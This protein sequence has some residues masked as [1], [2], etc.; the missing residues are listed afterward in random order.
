[1][2]VLRQVAGIGVVAC[3]VAPAW[4]QAPAPAPRARAK[5]KPTQVIVRDVS[6]APIQGVQVT[7]SGASQAEV[8]TNDQGIAPVPLGPGT[9]R[10]RF[11]HDSF[12]TLERDVTIRATAPAE[13]A[14]A[15]N[16][17]PPPPEPP[18]A[19]P[20]P[21]PARPTAVPAGPPVNI[22]I[23]DFVDR[24]YVGREPLKESILSCMPSATARLIQLREPVGEHTHAE[25]DEVLYVVAGDGAV[26]VGSQVMSV[27]PG[28]MTAIPRGLPHTI[29]RRGRNPL[30]VLSTL[31]G[32]PC[33]VGTTGASSK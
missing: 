27:S 13:I 23:P 10:L 25:M 20:A 32:A 21:E 6:G 17:A 3:L 5:P 26:R 33:P 29:E 15:L 9:V 28:S 22:S 24:S 16:R 18:P 8:E 19:P 30:I 7:V 31:A 2:N 14:V 4:A 12:I 11:E 1:M